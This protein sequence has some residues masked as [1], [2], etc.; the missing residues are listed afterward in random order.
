MIGYNLPK[1]LNIDDIEYDIQS[2]FRAVLDI[3]IAC[4]DPDLS[5]YEK[6]EV[7][8]QILYID[9]DK[10]PVHCYEEACKKAV[11][12]IDGGIDSDKKKPQ[13]K[14]IDWQ[15]DAAMIM[16]AVNKVAGKELRAEKYIHWWTFL[17]FFMEVEDG[18]FSQ[19]LSI[20]QKKAKHKKLEKWEREFERENS[21]LVKL[22]TVQSEEQK[23]EIENLE[24]WL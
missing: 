21:D 8:Y 11:A 5:D 15:Y 4:A 7:M 6:Q 9:A 16:P 10:I 20:R 19:V 2:D 17:G 22:P 1:S 3:L 12:F 24:K 23:K 13:K 18:L 14:L